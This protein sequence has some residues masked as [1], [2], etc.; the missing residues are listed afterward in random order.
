MCFSPQASFTAGA[1]LSMV[2]VATIIKAK[3]KQKPS[4]LPFAAIPLIFAVQQI[5]E[6]F[7]WLSLDNNWPVVQNVAA[8]IFAFFAY[9]WWPLFIPIAV[10]LW[11]IVLWRKRLIGVIEVVGLA[12]GGGLLYYIVEY[13]VVAHVV[14]RCI[15]YQIAS[16]LNI[17]L[18]AEGFYLIA[19][20][21][22]LFLSSRKPV[23]L[24]GVAA[25]VSLG[26]T[27]VFFRVAAVSVWCFFAALLSFIVY[28][29]IADRI[30]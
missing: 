30:P 13:P 10:S 21:A 7:V 11:E 18:Y 28:F 16:P 23:N 15:A 3:R 22:P 29:A 2:G 5:T 19:V 8:H 17:R 9:A 27:Y 24:F 20:L 1:A 4:A 25:V 14:N 26:V 6:G 12:V